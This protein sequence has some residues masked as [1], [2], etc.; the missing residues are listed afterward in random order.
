MQLITKT[1]QKK[2]NLMNIYEKNGSLYLEGIPEFNP[3]HIFENGQCFRWEKEDDD[4]YTIVAKNKVIN[5]ALLKEE[6]DLYN[7]RFE[8]CSLEDYN[9]I[10][11]EY[12]DMD[13]DYVKLRKALSQ[14]DQ[15][16]FEATNYG[17]GL[18]ILN[19]DIFEMTMSFIISANNQ[20]P[21]IKKAVDTMATLLGEP[22]GEF[23][24]KMRY[25]FPS[26]DD[27]ANISEENLA[28]LKIGFRAPYILNSSK[29]IQ[30]EEIKLIDIK[31]APYEEAA[32]ELQRLPGVGPKVADCI[33]L[34][35]AKKES[36]FPVDTW[37]IKFMNE[38]YM[39]A[40]DKNIKRIKAKGLEV[41]G[42]QAGFAQQYLFY[43]ARENKLA[44]RKE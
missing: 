33:L 42:E 2:G 21:R 31:F 23:K 6:N 24:G 13:R 32:K 29:M 27:V 38:Y 19:Q 30:K 18:R 22:I 44:A 43:Y 26:P 12:F 40:P 16:L 20:I 14:V 4:S 5:V 41:F 10:W 3:K 15:Y 35:G 39:D 25:S 28:A 36:A 1:F 11:H 34:F 37:V 7:L 17:K 9:N 8:G